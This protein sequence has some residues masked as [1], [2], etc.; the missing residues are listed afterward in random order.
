MQKYS[1]TDKIEVGP[2]SIKRTN[3]C[4]AS[5]VSETFSIQHTDGAEFSS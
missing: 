1:Y 2:D 5:K 4:L 3:L